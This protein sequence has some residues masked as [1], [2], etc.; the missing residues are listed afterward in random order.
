MAKG[1]NVGQIFLLLHLYHPK[2]ENLMNYDFYPFPSYKAEEKIK[3][4]KILAPFAPN[5]QI[6]E[7]FFK[8]KHITMYLYEII[9]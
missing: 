1:A 2:Y 8:S 7:I 9:I 6:L 4:F 5:Q 3:Q